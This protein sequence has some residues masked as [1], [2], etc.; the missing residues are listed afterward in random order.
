VTAYVTVSR[1]TSKVRWEDTTIKKGT[2]IAIGSPFPCSVAAHL[3]ETKP[4]MAMAIETARGSALSH[5]SARKS[6]TKLNQTVL[7]GD[8]CPLWIANDQE[9]ID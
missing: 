6:H 2:A 3:I 8:Y 1:R 7:T 5:L 9:T 4:I